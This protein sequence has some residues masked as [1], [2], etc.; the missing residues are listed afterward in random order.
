[1][2]AVGPGCGGNGTLSI[3]WFLLGAVLGVLFT[4]VSLDR[5]Y[6]EVTAQRLAAFSRNLMLE[7]GKAF[8]EAEDAKQRIKNSQMN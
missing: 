2:L 8:R 3:V 6:K 7:F 1:M 4:A 5:Y